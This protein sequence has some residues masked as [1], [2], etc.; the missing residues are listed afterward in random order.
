[1]P[2]NRPNL[3]V[4][5]QF[6]QELLSAAYTIQEHNDRLQREYQTPPPAQANLVSQLNSICPHCGAAKSA[7]QAECEHCRSDEFRPGE[8]MQRKWA[9]MW[10][11]SQQQDLWPERAPQIHDPASHEIPPLEI[12]RAPQFTGTHDFAAS[13]I[14]AA[15]FENKLDTEPIAPEQPEPVYGRGSGDRTNGNRANGNRVNGG[16]VNG[17]RTNGNSVNSDRV[18]GRANG[19]SAFSKPVLDKFEF[20][21]LS[22]ESNWNMEP[23][24]HELAEPKGVKHGLREDVLREDVLSQEGLRED[25]PRED[26][27]LEDSAVPV[28]A[29][30]SSA[31]DDLSLDEPDYAD[32]DLIDAD[33]TT[34][35]ISDA[36]PV[37]LVQRIAEWRV[38]LHFHRADLYLGTAVFVAALALLWPVAGSSQQPTLSLWERAL[39]TVGIAEAPQPV[40]H[41][42]GD[43]A[44]EVWVDPHSAL[45]YC[46]GEDQYGKT[47]DGRFNSQ[48]EAQMDRFEPASRSA[49]E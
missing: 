2:S 40:V 26:V 8:R 49:C 43:P 14:L 28:P 45:Y 12:K 46:P 10:L 34:L 38:K 32:A 33:D 27:A 24:D 9:S 15:P 30:H 20:G 18:N 13:G 25:L 11:L 17:D 6:F 37:S 5:Q 21:T 1:M 42:Q 7:D 44:I 29:F 16:G 41:L 36:A 48:R 47:A 4:D 31:T 35:N 3:T 39:V 22:P 23:A 19:K